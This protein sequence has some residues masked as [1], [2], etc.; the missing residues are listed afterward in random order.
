M[1]MTKVAFSAVQLGQYLR[2]I[3]GLKLPSQQTS[4]GDCICGLP[5]DRS[6]YH[7]FNCAQ[8]IH[9]L[10][11]KPTAE[12]RSSLVTRVVDEDFV[13]CDDSAC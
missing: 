9:P 11:S 13:V 2:F 5:N 8:W 7:R 6:G 12:H 3:L 1:T 4:N 10:Q